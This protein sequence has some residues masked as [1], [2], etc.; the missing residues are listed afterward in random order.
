M[1]AKKK[2]ET[3][4]N[5]SSGSG[6]TKL[7]CNVR[8]WIDWT[9]EHRTGAER[10]R[11]DADGIKGS[12]CVGWM[13]V[14]MRTAEKA[15]SSPSRRAASLAAFHDGDGVVYVTDGAES[16]DRRPSVRPSPSASVRPSAD[17]KRG[18]CRVCFALYKPETEAAVCP[19]S[20]GRNRRSVVGVATAG[21]VYSGFNFSFED[22][23]IKRAAFF[24]GLISV[25]GNAISAASHT[26][27]RRDKKRSC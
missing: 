9:D 4:P 3:G 12:R 10:A 18:S 6:M 8:K 1:S 15:S 2:V 14:D 23:F 17:A 19:L 26:L 24:V 22:A 27:W 21:Q 5:C 16:D 11:T 20:K 25:R 7:K 13:R